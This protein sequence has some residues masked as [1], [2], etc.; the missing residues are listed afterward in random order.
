[1]DINHSDPKLSVEEAW[2]PMTICI[3]YIYGCWQYHTPS[4]NIDCFLIFKQVW[5]QKC[6]V[7]KASVDVNISYY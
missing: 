4:A 6:A 5:T 7:Q 2:L 3:L 1:M